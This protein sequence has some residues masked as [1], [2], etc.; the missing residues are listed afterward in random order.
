MMSA[1]RVLALS[2]A[3][4]TA[5]ITLCPGRAGA[6][7]T[8]PTAAVVSVEFTSWVK[9]APA[10]RRTLEN[11]LAKGLTGSGWKVVE[12]GQTSQILA[13][14][15]RSRLTKCDADMCMIEL[16]QLTG[17]NFL[18]WA[19]AVEARGELSIELKLFDS[20][21][22][23]HPVDREHVSCARNDS[24][25]E[26]L[27][28]AMAD[29]AG[30][31]GR[32]AMKRARELYPEVGPAPAPAVSP[33]PVSV[34]PSIT[35]PAAPPAQAVQHPGPLQPQPEPKPVTESPSRLRTILGW[36]SLGISVPLFGAAGYYLNRDGQGADCQ[37]TPAGERCLKVYDDK[38][39][40][41][42]FGALGLVAA[43]AGAYLLLFRSHDGDTSIALTP[44]GFV[45]GGR[46]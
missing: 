21:D 35:V 40:A 7:E 11:S 9:V 38:P 37:S 12:A 8:K 42:V 6:G 23:S 45:L 4:G 2:L 24:R 30:T 44:N 28:Q 1:V 20:T 18:V 39:R 3:V 43:G 29:L 5:A 16:S 19:K 31:L 10:D 33:P 14:N 46:Y 27:G 17:A 13:K 26:S 34:P 25:C 22:A 36:T 41:Y 15:G 32:K